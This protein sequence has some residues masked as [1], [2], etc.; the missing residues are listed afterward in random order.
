MV[1]HKNHQNSPSLTP[2]PNQYL[3]SII[4]VEHTTFY[5]DTIL[6]IDSY[7]RENTIS[8]LLPSDKKSILLSPEPTT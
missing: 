1:N 8:R 6:W 4:T 7:V 5:G 3:Y 2:H